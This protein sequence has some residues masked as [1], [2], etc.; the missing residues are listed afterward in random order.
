MQ[1]KIKLLGSFRDPSGF[2]FLKDGQIYRQINRSYQ[3]DY[4]HL[5]SS[6]LF[7]RLVEDGLLCSHNE[8]S[9]VMYPCNQAYKVIK[10][11]IIPFISY[12]H[13]WCFS[14]IK[15]AALAT[16]KIQQ[17]AL[18]Y[19]MILKDA[20]AYNIQ[21]K[22]G[23][24]ILI[25]TLSFE[26]YLEGS[27]WK[28]YKQFCQ[29]FIAPLSLMAYRDV[30]LNQLQRAYIDGIPL[31]LTSSLLPIWTY[32]RF[33]ILS[34][35]HIHARLQK[36]YSNKNLKSQKIFISRDKLIALVN[37]L[38]SAVTKIKMNHYKT[39]WWTYYNDTSYSKEAF[40]QKQGLIDRFIK[41]IRPA[42]VWDLGANTG[43]FSKIVSKNGVDTLSID[44]DHDVVEANYLNCKQNNEK[45]ILPLVLDLA[46]PTSRF[47][48]SNEERMSII[49]RAPVD[50]ILALALV[51]HLR[52]TNNTPLDHI[53]HFFSKICKWLIIEFVPK[54]DPK[55]QTL[56]K[57]KDDI[58]YDY[59]KMD[60]EMIFKEHFE[61]INSIQVIDSERFLYLMKVKNI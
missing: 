5:I 52:V 21:F 58:Y 51:H 8:L 32:L 55:F 28:A 3:E 37:V 11:E 29:H 33:Q 61:I 13:E 26:K 53:A 38:K 2:V 4:D 18:N 27:P 59:Y 56:I 12:P 47:G 40:N 9:E 10:P 7:K 42:M 60:F 20:S 48:W 41:D 46:N 16:L 43:L 23:H 35:I 14:Q 6:G 50:L 54:T 1:E 17:V 34:N 31:D 25:D 19:N 57:N 39:E 44:F 24:P 36:S 30:R 15:D 22:D 49:D 45:H